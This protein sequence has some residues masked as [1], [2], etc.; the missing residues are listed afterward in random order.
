MLRLRA[1]GFLLALIIIVGGCKS[2]T[3]PSGTTGNSKPDTTVI[4]NHVLFAINGM[5]S[6]NG[7]TYHASVPE[8]TVDFDLSAP[9]GDGTWS[10]KLHTADFPPATNYVTRSFTNLS[11]GVYSLTTLLHMK[12]ILQ[13]GTFPPGWMAIIKTN[14]GV[15]STKTQLTLDTDQW[16]SERLLDTLS[17]LPSD[18]VTLQLSAGCRATTGSLHGNPVWFDDITFKRL[19]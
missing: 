15:S 7:W 13:E 4:L 1:F 11:S 18:T 17:L 12:Y 16:H 2:S 3:S 14:G 10:L 8:D 9:P 19:P 5:P 6:L